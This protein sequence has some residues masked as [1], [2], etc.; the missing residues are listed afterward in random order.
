MLSVTPPGWTRADGWIRTSMGRFT[1]PVPFY[2]EPHR[3]KQECKDSNPVERL[4]R[5]QALP[6]AHS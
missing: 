6:G 1:R 4:W 3:R 2:F 5:P